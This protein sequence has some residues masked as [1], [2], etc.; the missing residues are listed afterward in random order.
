MGLFRENFHWR[1]RTPL[2]GVVPRKILLAVSPGCSSIFLVAF[3]SLL[4]A[5][6]RAAK[7]RFARREVQPNRP[8]RA[9]GITREK[10]R[11]G[12]AI[13]RVY[14]VIPGGYEHGED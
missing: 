7:L 11:N 5:H 14:S 13:R 12:R 9:L 4:V 1:A 2:H 10:G 3:R 6:V 8:W